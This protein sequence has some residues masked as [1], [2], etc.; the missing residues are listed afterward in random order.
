VSE[1]EFQARKQSYYSDDGV[2][3]QI[4]TRTAGRNAKRTDVKRHKQGIQRSILIRL[5]MMEAKIE[6]RRRIRL[7]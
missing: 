4:A 2:I 1:H 6:K 7:N 3:S 5:H